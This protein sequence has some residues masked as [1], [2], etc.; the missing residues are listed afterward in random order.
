[1]QFQYPYKRY[2]KNPY[3]ETQG[4]MCLSYNPILSCKFSSCCR[5]ETDSVLYIHIQTDLGRAGKRW[6]E[7]G[8]AG[9]LSTHCYCGTLAGGK[10]A[11]QLRKSMLCLFLPDKKVYRDQF[12]CPSWACILSLLGIISVSCVPAL[13]LKEPQRLGKTKREHVSSYW[14]IPPPPPRTRSATEE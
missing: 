6:R 9:D 14:G 10:S 12:I 13:R 7:V 11:E 1:M 4:V 3:T 5:R 8:G 2:C